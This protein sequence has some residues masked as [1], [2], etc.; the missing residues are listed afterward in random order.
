MLELCSFEFGCSKS[1][2]LAAGSDALKLRLLLACLVVLVAS[3]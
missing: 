2:E 3:V 1:H